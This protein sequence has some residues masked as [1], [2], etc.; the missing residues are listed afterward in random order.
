M[1]AHSLDSATPLGIADVASIAK[2]VVAEVERAV[3]GKSEAIS[4]VLVG[5]LA[6]GH[7]LLED[8]PGLAKTLIVRS[9]ARVLGSEM[10]RIQ[11]TPD[12]M[13]ADVTGSGSSTSPAGSSYSDP[14]QCSQTSCWATRSIVLLRRPKR[15]CSR[16]C[17]SNR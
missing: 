14:D 12:L 9:L 4:L 8:V 16:P 6:G 13:P 17:R 3:V 7:V 1:T 10:S 11:F 15:H 2:D 5:V